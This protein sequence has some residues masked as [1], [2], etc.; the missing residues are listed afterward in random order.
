MI[1]S[2]ILNYKIIKQIGEGGMGTIYLGKHLTLDRFVAI[3]V[4]LPEFANNSEIKERFINEARTLSKLSHQ[5]IVS[6]YDFAEVDNNLFL[7]MEYIE[8]IPLDDYIL[9]YGSIEEG[10]CINIFNQILDGFSYAHSMNI[11]HRDI[12]PSNIILQNDLKPKILDFGI[13]KILHGDI[14]LTQTGTRVGSILYMSPEQVLGKDIDQR[15]DIYSLGITFTEMLTGRFPYNIEN[16]SDYEIQHSIVNNEIPL[17]NS[18]GDGFSLNTINAVRIS[19]LKNPMNRFTTCEDF[20]KAISENTGSEFSNKLSFDKTTISTSYKPTQTVIDRGSSESN[21]PRRNSNITY[22]L[23]GVLLIIIAILIFVFANNENGIKTSLPKETSI[24]K[25]GNISNNGNN[26]GSESNKSQDETEKAEII[27]T[28]TSI[29]DAW[30]NK[31]IEGFFGKL[32]SDYHYESVEGVK[33][34]F[35]ER[36][37]KAYEI[38]SANR[39]IRIKTEDMTVDITGN[40]AVVKYYQRYSSTTVNEST[41]KKMYLRKENSKWLVYKE[42]SGFN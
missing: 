35:S 22:Y 24:E 34:T 27:K 31:N 1:G 38:F 39:F 26:S 37:S 13:A 18:Y 2:Q 29:L 5:N 19:T 16:K 33:R 23:G 15:S 30:Q 21:Q 25:K 17:L 40:T 41:T 3:K 36:K 6:L 20:K 4:L 42:L 7:I 10:K 12:K 32:T 8:G 9:K 14:R 28:V 11:V